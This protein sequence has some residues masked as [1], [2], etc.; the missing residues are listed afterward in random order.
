MWYEIFMASVFSLRS[1]KKGSHKMTF[2]L[3][4]NYLVYSEYGIIDV[5]RRTI[6][7]CN[8]EKNRHHW[9]VYQVI[10][11]IFLL[12]SLPTQSSTCSSRI[13][14]HNQGLGKCYQPLLSAD[15]TYLDLDYSGYHRNLIQ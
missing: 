3:Q 5:K 1:I 13:R 4:K 11:L 10:Q 7:Q 2:R 6:V 15:N 9:N 12:L 14:C 8:Y